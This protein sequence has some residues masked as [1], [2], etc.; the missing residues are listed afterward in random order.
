MLIGDTKGSGFM[1]WSTTCKIIP[2][3]HIGLC[4]DV[5]DAGFGV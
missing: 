1:V 2:V 3:G 5:G 4:A